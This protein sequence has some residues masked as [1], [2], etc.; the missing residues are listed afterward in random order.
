MQAHPSFGLGQPSSAVTSFISRIENADP[1]SPDMSEDDT[2]ESWGHYQFTSGDMK[3]TTVLTSWGDIGNV[4]AARRLIA[5]AIKTCKVARYICFQRGVDTA[6]YLSDMYLGIV[7]ERLWKFWQDAGG[8]RTHYSTCFILIF[9][10]H[11]LCRRK[12]RVPATL[13]RV[14]VLALL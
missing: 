10:V 12:R 11:S 1:N 7:I 14:L 8:V 2:N 5:A 9:Y 13:P 3:C 6:S 4:D